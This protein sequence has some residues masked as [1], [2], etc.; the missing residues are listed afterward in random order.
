MP[1]ELK[2]PSNLKAAWKVKIFDK[3]ELEPPHATILKGPDMWR[4]GLRDGRFLIPPGGSWGDFP[5]DLQKVLKNEEAVSILRRE[6]DRLH[7]NN[8]VGGENE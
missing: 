3:E 4:L 6:W 8:P 5:K 7:P 2:L 1:F